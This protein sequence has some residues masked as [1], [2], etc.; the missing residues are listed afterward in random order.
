[1]IGNFADQPVGEKSNA[2]AS[3]SVA[4]HDL[5]VSRGRRGTGA[6]INSSHFIEGGKND[7]IANGISC[8]NDASSIIANG[9]ADQDDAQVLDGSEPVDCAMDGRTVGFAN[10]IDNFP[11]PEMP[12]TRLCECPNRLE[13]LGHIAFLG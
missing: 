8:R 5:I 4:D 11:I 9:V 1:M 7:D 10:D 12:P 3:S 6:D 13:L 2:A